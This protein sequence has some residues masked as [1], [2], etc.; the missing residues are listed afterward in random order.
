MM[1]LLHIA[2]SFAILTL[3]AGALL[4]AWAKRETGC[5]A[6]LKFVGYTVIVLAISNLLCIGYYGVRYWEDGVFKTPVTLNQ[7]TGMG[8]MGGG[9]GNS[10]MNMADMM[11]MMKM[12]HD[13]GMMECPM[14]KNGGMMQGET[15]D[16]STMPAPGA[17]PSA[18]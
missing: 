10:G 18:P 4:L 2:F 1:F 8:M 11:G 7:N 3:V 15:K 5:N 17:A 6:K 12:M 9:M 16:N 14:M 13:K